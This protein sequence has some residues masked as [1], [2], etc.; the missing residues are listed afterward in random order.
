MG[1]AFEAPVA[2]PTYRPLTRALALA[3]VLGLL[4]WTGASVLRAHDALGPAHWAAGAAILG[5]LLW[6]LP[7]LL[8][9]RTEVDARGVR[10]L[11]WQGREVLWSEVARARF[12]RLPGAPRL[13]L[14]TGFGR[15]KAFHSGS[16]ALD[17]AFE[18]AARIL[19]DAGPR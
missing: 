14:S 12:L 13:L 15:V 18:R 1:R 19:S 3:L 6:P 8:L 10:Q 11:G 7:A 9:G 5:A 2:G 17:E 4:G 16:P